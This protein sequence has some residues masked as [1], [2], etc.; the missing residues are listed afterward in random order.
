MEKRVQ[1]LK[2]F[3]T[4]KNLKILLRNILIPRD[5]YTQLSYKDRIKDINYH[6]I[7]NVYWHLNPRRLEQR[8]C[9]IYKKSQL[10]LKLGI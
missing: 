1:R 2:R 6:P 9:N 4:I 7:V 5:D 3:S 8:S 10:L